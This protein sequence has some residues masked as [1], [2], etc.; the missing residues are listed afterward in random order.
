MTVKRNDACWKPV[1]LRS[2]KE[3]RSMFDEVE[4]LVLTQQG[5]T[6]IIRIHYRN[7]NCSYWDFVC[8]FREHHLKVELEI[9]HL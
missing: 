4:L 9:G 6:L 5:E 2:S 3:Y 7:L 1:Q 8:L